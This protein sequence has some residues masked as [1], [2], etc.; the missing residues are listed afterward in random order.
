MPELDVTR[1]GGATGALKRA[2][3]LANMRAANAARMADQLR[4]RRNRQAG[5]PSGWFDPGGMRYNNGRSAALPVQMP[6]RPPP[7]ARRPTG[8]R[9]V[10]RQPERE[11]DLLGLGQFNSTPDGDSYFDTYMRDLNPAT[12]ADTT[13]VQLVDEKTGKPGVTLP[14]KSALPVTTGDYLNRAPAEIERFEKMSPKDQAEVRANV[15]KGNSPAKVYDKTMKHMLDLINRDPMKDPMRSGA[16]RELV[17]AFRDASKTRYFT[18]DDLLDNP[19]LN[20]LNELSVW[21]DFRLRLQEFND[22]KRKTGDV[23]LTGGDSETGDGAYGSM[24]DVGSFSQDTGPGNLSKWIVARDENGLLQVVSAGQWIQAKWARMRHDPKYAA[25]MI[26]ALAATS[27]Y[28]TDSTANN[29]RTRLVMDRDGNPVKG[30]PGEEDLM[31]LK[32][33]AL[34]VAI[35]QGQGDESAIDDSIAELTKVAFDVTAQAAKNGDLGGDGYGGGWGGGGGGWGGGY[36]G[37]GGG[38]EGAVRYTDGT[39]LTSMVSSIAR[40]RMGRELTPEEAAAFV[41]YYH[42]LEETNSAAY[43]ANQSTTMLDPE[44]QAVAWITGH[45]EDEAAQNQYGQLA[46]QFFTMMGSSNPFG[47]IAD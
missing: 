23:E 3:Q 18:N 20:I 41:A 6:R 32:D 16:A 39:Q 22:N 12:R 17:D 35:L 30:F 31:A 1:A 42:K 8:P 5:R 28:G 44:G 45:F 37:G 13:D 25:Q 36:G 29:Q 10:S 26:T 24:A 7:P 27:A 14:G 21:A 19:V 4:Q 33:L 34:Q 40:Q 47:S 43:Y 9:G 15:E 46:A 11:R 2:T 38:G